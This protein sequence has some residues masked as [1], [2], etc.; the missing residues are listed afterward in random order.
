MTARGSRLPDDWE[1]N[2]Q[3]IHWGLNELGWR[4]FQIDSVVQTFRDYWH[5]EAGQRARKLDWDLTFKNWC[6]REGTQ[7][8]PNG[9]NGKKSMAT[10]AMEMARES[11]DGSDLGGKIGE[12]DGPMLD[13]TLGEY[14]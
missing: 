12:G 2:P 5:A 14:G 8:K 11:D 7:H 10:I 4:L 9:S 13:L 1:P 3:T 6:R